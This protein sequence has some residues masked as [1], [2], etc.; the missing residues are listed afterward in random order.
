[1]TLITTRPPVRPVAPSAPAAPAHADEERLLA[2][3]PP[4]GVP[5]DGFVDAV[6]AIGTLLVIAL[7]W[8]MADAAWNG[9]RLEVS[10]ALASGP[11]PFLTWL[12]PLP[13]LFFAAGASAVY[14]LARDPRPLADGWRAGPRLGADRVRRLLPPVAVFAGMWLVLAA[15]LMVAG[16]PGEVVGR[17]ARIVPQPLWFLG[18]YVLLAALTPL[19]RGLLRAGGA[20]TVAVVVV[21]PFAVDALRFGAGWNWIGPVNVIL[22]WAVPYVIGMAYADRRASGRALPRGPVLAGLLAGSV[23]AAVLVA[24]GP[25]PLSLIGMPGDA[26]SNLAPPTAP[27]VA[28]AVAQV[29]LVLLLAGPVRAWAGRSG[30]VRWVGARSMPLYLWHLTAMFLVVGLELVLGAMPVPWSLGWFV[31]LPVRAAAAAVVLVLLTAAAA[32]VAHRPRPLGPG[33]GTRDSSAARVG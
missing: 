9:T 22:A 12:Q 26:I 21:A 24:A 27:V 28:Y 20:W 1:M 19:L 17:V 11:G 18:V 2:V 31:V 7:H 8:L 15:G 32:R 23:G 13:L 16:V 33:V 6:R 4:A 14:G 3:A 30:L 10:N 5:R 25:Y 29:C